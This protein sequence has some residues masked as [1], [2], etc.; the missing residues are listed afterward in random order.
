MNFSE[1]YQKN[2]IIDEKKIFY[3]LNFTDREI[4]DNF[5]IN[6]RYEK[7]DLITIKK[8]MELDRLE[9]QYNFL[10]N[11]AY[12]DYIGDIDKDNFLFN[13]KNIDNIKNLYNLYKNFIKCL[14]ERMFDKI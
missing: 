12:T 8:N 11:R 2:W 4:Y 1:D 14:Y 13:G 7:F 3:D 9:K 10:L 5:D 6:L